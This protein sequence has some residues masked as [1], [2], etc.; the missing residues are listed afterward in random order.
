MLKKFTRPLVA[1]TIALVTGIGVAVM[2][3]SSANA[4]DAYD[5]QGWFT[6]SSQS[7]PAGGTFTVSNMPE[8]VGEA[9]WQSKVLV[10][11]ESNQATPPVGGP[12]WG[13]GG[14]MGE[15]GN[16]LISSQ[17]VASVNGAW[18]AT[19]TVPADTAPGSGFQIG[20]AFASLDE[21][22][23]IDGFGEGGCTS[24]TITPFVAAPAPAPA[25]D[26]LLGTVETESG[27]VALPGGGDSVAPGAAFR[28]RIS[29]G[30]GEEV[31]ITVTLPGTPAPGIVVAG[32][33][34]RTT[35]T[36]AEGNAFFSIRVPRGTPAGMGHVIG[37]NS[38][39]HEIF[40][41]EFLI[42]GRAVHP[43]AG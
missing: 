9:T 37:T 40:R 33:A 42:S 26:E 11:F 21:N 10:R 2:A 27:G 29:A 32:A 23:Q 30:A 22:G 5:G 28:A 36:D 25:P 15:C 7:V 31:T 20:V 6:L 8:D 24:L 4:A 35:T 13:G 43:A 38:A 12:G 41:S 34:S 16:V 1:S 39:G 14:N 18:S 19:F 3:A 17:E